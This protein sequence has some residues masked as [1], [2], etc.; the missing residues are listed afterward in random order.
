[1][2][3]LLEKIPADLILLEPQHLNEVYAG[4]IE[5]ENTNPGREKVSSENASVLHYDRECLQLNGNNL[6]LDIPMPV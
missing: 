3:A 2:K 6:I 1:M 4:K 5:N